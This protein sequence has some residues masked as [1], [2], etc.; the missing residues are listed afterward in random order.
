MSLSSCTI[1]FKI[2]AR[3]IPN[4]KSHFDRYK[5]IGRSVAMFLI[6]Q[7]AIHILSNVKI[8]YP[9]IHDC[10]PIPRYL[11]GLRRSSCRIRVRLEM[12]LKNFPK[13]IN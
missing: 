11:M 13:H 2:A 4:L 6:G 7:E 10:V 5:R 8:R 9:E 3:K 1:V 12:I